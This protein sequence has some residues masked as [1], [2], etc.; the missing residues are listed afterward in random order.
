[1]LDWI[2]NHPFLGELWFLYITFH[3]PFQWV[4]MTIIGYTAWGQRKQKRE[5]DILIEELRAEL[6]HVHQEVHAH[7]EE[8]SALH[9]DLGQKGKMTPGEPYGSKNK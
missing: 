4:V 2:L 1:M 5:R 8:D 7:I 6:A 3:D 9:E